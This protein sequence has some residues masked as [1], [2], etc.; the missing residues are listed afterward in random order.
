MPDRIHV[1]APQPRP[2]A[3]LGELA[4]VLGRHRLLVGACGA[5]ALAAGAGVAAWI[6]PVY[7]TAALIRVDERAG[8]NAP[9]GLEVLSGLAPGTAVGTEVEV[10]RSRALAAEVAGALALRL[11]LAGPRRVAR[12]DAFAWMSVQ[13]DAPAGEYLL[14][15]RADGGWTLRAGDGTPLERFVRGDTLRLPGVR[16]VPARGAAS[17][18]TLRVRVR[19]A[20]QAVE[21][22]LAG[23]EVQRTSRDAG[24]VRV[25]YRA[26]DAG[27]ARDVPNEIAA[28]FVAL[29]SDL[30]KTEAR[31]TAAFLRRQL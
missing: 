30:Q 11:E 1:P 21:G 6:T 16:L 8:G 10:L 18:G 29:R 3:P 31:S 17:A 22:V 9:P 25:R 24:V 27:L 20:E 2:A 4:G 28:R 13:R 23:L 14:S 12:G 7:E 5:A 19:S 26:A 15:P